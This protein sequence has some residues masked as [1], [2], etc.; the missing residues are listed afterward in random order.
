MN[1]Q[2]NT[3]LTET[4]FRAWLRL[5]HA[6]QTA[7]ARVE[8]ALKAADL[9]PLPWYDAL[10]EL[11]HAGEDGL[12]PQQLEKELMLPQY[13]LSRLL[14]RI[15]AEGYLVRRAFAGDRRG[16][17]IAITDSGKA[18]RRRMW[19]VYAEAIGEAFGRRL[20]DEDAAALDHLLAKVI[21]D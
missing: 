17:I 14:D 3:R 21:P 13:S 19:P 1:A 9:P 7:F 4:T 18:L 15:A 20:S 10:L 12:R 5:L 11:E 6:H 2:E 8:A 16:Q